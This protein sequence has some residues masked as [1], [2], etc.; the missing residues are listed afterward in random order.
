MTNKFTI[1]KLYTNNRTGA[2][3]ECVWI[4]SNKIHFIHNARSIRVAKSKYSW[5]GRKVIWGITIAR[6]SWTPVEIDKKFNIGY[7][8]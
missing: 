8:R 6:E 1:G 7:W 2:C 4:T 3:F 5:I